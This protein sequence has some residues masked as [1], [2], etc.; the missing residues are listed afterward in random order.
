M[1]NRTFSTRQA[2]WRQDRASLMQVRHKVFVD[3][4]GV[5][6]EIEMDKADAHAIHL[7]AEDSAGNPIGTLRL[8]SN[9]QIG[10]MAVLKAW[11]GNGVGSA[12]MT[13][14]LN[15]PAAISGPPPFLNAQT[16]AIPFYQYHGFIPVGEVFMEAGIPHR[17]MEI[18]A[19]DQSKI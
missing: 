10:R 3:E 2:R 19:Y 14:I 4:Q 15:H 7:L 16:Q 13:T 17:R 11:R 18:P 5:P 12:L 8:L 1:S 6:A 9:G